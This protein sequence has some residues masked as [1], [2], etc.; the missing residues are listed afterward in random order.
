MLCWR[1]GLREIGLRG[2]AGYDDSSANEPQIAW[3]NL[4]KRDLLID[5]TG[6][7][8]LVA[9]LFDP[10]HCLGIARPLYSLLFRLAK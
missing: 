5:H 4:R 9:G 2:A 7:F 6:R 1:V 10:L 8:V 3:A